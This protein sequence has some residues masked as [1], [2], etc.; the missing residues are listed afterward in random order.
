MSL[1][2][3][4]SAQI[5]TAATQG[6]KRGWHSVQ[7]PTLRV[8]EIGFSEVLDALNPLNHLPGFASSA[9]PEETH[10][11]TQMTKLA[12]GFLLGGPLG[13][14]VSA[15]DSVFE[16]ATGKS[17]L[18]SV[19]HAVMGDGDSS[20]V[21]AQRYANAAE[22]QNGAKLQNEVLL[23]PSLDGLPTDNLPVDRRA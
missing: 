15:V 6:Q 4:T 18:G 5:Q 8:E 2:N 9:A 3:L 14:A 10:P 7:K 17:A 19:Y 21:A 13:L 20:T 12:G 23:P 22:L 11:L 1:G 16:A